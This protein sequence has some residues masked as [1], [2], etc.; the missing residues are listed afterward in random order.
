MAGEIGASVPKR[1]Q[2]ARLTMSARTPFLEFAGDF[3]RFAGARSAYAGVFL[4]L[5]AVLEGMG[6]LL[7]VPLL[8]VV[9]GRRSGNQ[10]LDDFT[11]W[12]MSFIPNPT[13]MVQLSLVLVLFGLIIAARAFV[14]TNRDV[15]LA[16]L[17]VEF[18]E[19]HRLRIITGLAHSPWERIAALRHARVTHVLGADI[20]A[21]A[22]A[23]GLLLHLAVACTLLIG[24][25]AL[26][27]FLSPGLAVLIFVLLVGAAFGL[28]PV[29]K[30][31]RDL[32]ESLTQANLV[33]VT[34]TSQ[35]LGALKL[36]LSQN[37]QSSFVA[38]FEATLSDSAEQRIEFARQRAKTQVALVCAGAFIASIVVLAGLGVFHAPAA[39]LLA[40]LFI[41]SRM[42]APLSQIQAGAQHIFH[43]LPA[44]RKIRELEVELAREPDPLSGPEDTGGPTSNPLDGDIVFRDVSFWHQAS[45]PGAEKGPGV[46]DLNLVIERGSIVG[47]TGASGAGKSTFCDL[48]VGLYTPTAGEVA[49]GDQLLRGSAVTQWRSGLSYVS[50]EPFLFHDTIRSNLLW[51]RPEAS[52]DDLWEAL[53]TAG[54]EGLVR[55]LDQGLDTVVGERGSRLS[56]GERQRVALARAL[57]RKP[58]LLVLD[59]ATNALDSASEAALHRRLSVLKPRPTVVIVAHRDSSLLSCTRILEIGAGR[60]VSYS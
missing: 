41:L 47:L 7:L 9:L 50:Q 12:L 36:A 6:L 28:Q 34:S 3:L 35:F 42:T 4:A 2:F 43:S 8:S 23:S 58:R 38:G 25:G 55:G 59:E 16:R 56:G 18:V 11:A 26:I 33:L 27:M 53:V 52:E 21:C 29:L 19:S 39:S 30:R 37:L 14:I 51:A 45:L 54:A 10:R 20:Q 40:F 22:D 44:Y 60:M 13:P 15:S 46:H 32:G 49:I 17:Q 57:L 24:H 48:L 1:R 5:G 31:S